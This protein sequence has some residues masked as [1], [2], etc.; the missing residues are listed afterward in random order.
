[1]YVQK[2]G[3]RFD[4]TGTERGTFGGKKRIHLKTVNTLFLIIGEF[5]P[6]FLS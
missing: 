3:S 5:H 4:L 6:V 1:M 2:A